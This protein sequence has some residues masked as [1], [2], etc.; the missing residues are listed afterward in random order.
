MQLL[1]CML[2]DSDHRFTIAEVKIFLQE[3]MLARSHGDS[4]YGA[5]S[6]TCA[7]SVLSASKPSPLPS[8]PGI[9]VSD[10]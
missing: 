10:V 4:A 5:V 6:N 8:K 3:H 9:T 2:T 1:R 7:T